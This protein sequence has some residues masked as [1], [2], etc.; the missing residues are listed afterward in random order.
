MTAHFNLP[1][2]IEENQNVTFASA[3][4]HCHGTCIEFP[5]P[6]YQGSMLTHCQSSHIVLL[7]CHIAN[8]SVLFVD[9]C[10]LLFVWLLHFLL[11]LFFNSWEQ[12]PGRPLYNCTIC[13][14]NDRTSQLDF[15]TIVHIVMWC[16][17]TLYL[18]VVVAACS[19]LA[20]C[21][22]NQAFETG[23]VHEIVISFISSISSGLTI[24]LISSE[25]RQRVQYMYLT[26]VYI[27][28]PVPK[29][30]FNFSVSGKTSWKHV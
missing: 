5:L 7:Y 12:I 11:M 26:N 2:I 15:Q 16:Y 6:E 28:S 27:T 13:A 21:Y 1:A 30:C 23:I 25:L 20:S 9:D 3:K 4:S 10:Y 17:I 8:S 29:K 24:L 19:V 14:L 22:K 18:A